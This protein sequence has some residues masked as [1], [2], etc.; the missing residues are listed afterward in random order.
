MLRNSFRFDPSF[1]VSEWSCEEELIGDFLK[2]LRRYLPYAVVSYED[3]IT[4]DVTNILL[5][6]TNLS[7]LDKGSF[8]KIFSDVTTK[9]EVNRTCRLDHPDD[10]ICVEHGYTYV[11]NFIDFPDCSMDKAIKEFEEFRRV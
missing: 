3:D 1:Y 8:F 11:F 10:L 7:D 6:M 9:N 2:I 5:K 4:G